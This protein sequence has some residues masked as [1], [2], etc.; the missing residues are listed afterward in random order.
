MSA[1]RPLSIRQS[2][3]SPAPAPS[4]AVTAAVPPTTRSSLTALFPSNENAPDKQQ[5]FQSKSVTSVS[6]SVPATP[7]AKDRNYYGGN[8]KVE[9]QSVSQ[10]LMAES[11]TAV[12]VHVSEETK[13]NFSGSVNFPSKELNAESPVVFGNTTV[14]VVS[15]A[16]DEIGPKATPDAVSSPIVAAERRSSA[17]ARTSI[18][19]SPIPSDSIPSVS[20][21]R[22]QRTR[23]APREPVATPFESSFQATDYSNEHD[24]VIGAGAAWVSAEDA[25]TVKAAMEKG[26]EE[27]SALDVISPLPLLSSVVEK[28][29][30][31]E[32]AEAPSVKVETPEVPPVVP[33][34]SAPAGLQEK[35]FSPPHRAV[36]ADATSELS[37]AKNASISQTTPYSENVMSSEPTVKQSEHEK[38]DAI[39]SEA[40]LLS[41]VDVSSQ[42]S[43]DLV[44][45]GD[46][47]LECAVEQRPTSTRLPFKPTNI[48]PRPD[49]GNILSSLE[50]FDTPTD[51]PQDTVN[52][53]KDF[54]LEPEKVHETPPSVPVA[55]PVVSYGMK[56]LPDYSFD[57]FTSAVQPVTEMPAEKTV[58]FAMPPSLPP[59]PPL[60]AAGSVAS[61]VAGPPAAVAVALSPPLVVSK[62]SSHQA[63]PA[64]SPPVPMAA[65][66]KAGDAHLTSRITSNGNAETKD[67]L[68][69]EDS[70][71]REGEP[72][73]SVLPSFPTNPSVAPLSPPMEAPAVNAVHITEESSDQDELIVS[74][75]AR[76]DPSASPEFA[77]PHLRMSISKTRVPQF[78]LYRHSDSAGSG[79]DDEGEQETPFPAAFGA[80]W[81]KDPAVDMGNEDAGESS[82]DDE[83]A[84][85]NNNDEEQTPVQ[86]EPIIADV[87]E[88]AP[89]TDGAIVVEEMYPNEVIYE[90]PV[91]AVHA[92]SLRE[93]AVPL[94]EEVTAPS[95]LRSSP[96]DVPAFASAPSTPVDVV[97]VAATTSDSMTS[98]QPSDASESLLQTPQKYSGS[99]TSATVESWETA[100]ETS[101]PR[102]TATA[103][104]R[105]ASTVHTPEKALE[106]KEDVIVS[107]FSPSPELVVQQ[108]EE[109]S[110]H[111]PSVAVPSPLATAVASVLTFVNEEMVDT[112]M[113]PVVHHEGMYAQLAHTTSPARHDTIATGSAVTP[114]RETVHTSAG[115]CPA[116]PSSELPSSTGSESAPHRTGINSAEEALT[117]ERELQSHTIQTFLIPEAVEEG[118][119]VEEEEEEDVEAFDDSILPDTFTTHRM[120]SDPQPFTASALPSLPELPVPAGM[121]GQLAHS[122]MPVRPV[123]VP[124]SVSSGNDAATAK[125]KTLRST[126]W[127][128]LRKKST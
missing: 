60:S 74:A 45:S 44:K 101:T 124:I 7:V 55:D 108:T 81:E 118:D 66:A 33:H 109:T 87:V 31:D 49:K 96:V 123:S 121:Y 15:A 22:F 34:A 64:L 120:L 95:L 21:I 79:S 110:S 35:E 48:E 16:S 26:T 29:A 92:Q 30:C 57:A 18:R 128:W 98:A 65:E 72:V 10:G 17:L 58:S 20:P 93:E 54:T 37:M 126:R 125:T 105:V 13:T 52:F 88:R 50:L 5:S 9:Q 2:Q 113:K 14:Q 73:T 47:T 23:C 61:P 27:R 114:G 71:P 1:S 102:L 107:P 68:L 43:L 86:T 122:A 83:A 119:D 80:T 11:F 117:L 51:E 36:H 90:S 116:G 115:I 106:Q 46:S 56:G 63:A 12:R 4:P 89:A 38:I 6:A 32:V 103:T 41:D 39:H 67:E 53:E 25:P 19:T 97:T 24:Q 40:L 75:P 8:A 76:P 28:V 100:P 91:V 112:A 42:K 127:S 59:P 78:L 111:R 70:V 82:A 104:E 3:V 62:T 84:E 69:E 94:V 85:E 99:D 77:K